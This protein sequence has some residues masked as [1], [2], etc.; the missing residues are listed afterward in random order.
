MPKSIPDIVYLKTKNNIYV[1]SPVSTYR[2]PF[3][4]DPEYFSNWES[5]TQFVKEVEKMVRHNDR[6]NKYIYY[7]KN[8][9]KL[10]HC[11]VLSNLDDEDCTIEMHH[12]PIFNLYDYC[13]I[14]LEYFLL[15]GW[16]I[17]TFKIA[18]TVLREHE[19]NHIQVVML[20]S[21]VHQEVH[22]R[23]IFINYRHAY[24][25]LNA[26]IRRYGIAL[27]DDHKEKLNRYIDKSMM[28]DSTDYGLLTLN[29][30]LY[31]R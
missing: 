8:E 15:R 3:Y 14:I 12:G 1:D 16:D 9:V 5:Y 18:D 26:F 27:N 28:I 24:G 25:D 31:E 23:D 17:T 22:A 20:S 19:K 21:T 10:N 11:Q 4:K 7:L 6:Y 13:E 30:S 29:N 2:I